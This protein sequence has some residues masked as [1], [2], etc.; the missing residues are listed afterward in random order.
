MNSP[1][2]RTFRSVF[3]LVV[4]S[5]L[6]S[7]GCGDDGSGPEGEKTGATLEGQIVGSSGSGITATSSRNAVRPRAAPS[8]W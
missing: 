7:S 1:M 6:A 4:L 3:F 8:G 5:G 2:C